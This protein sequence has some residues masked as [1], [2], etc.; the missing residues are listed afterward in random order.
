MIFLFVCGF[1][2]KVENRV[3]FLDPGHGGID[4]GCISNKGVYEKGIVL[5]IAYYVKDYLEINGYNVMMTRYGDYDLASDYS[6]NRKHEDILRRV[7]MIN[8]N[9]CYAVISLHA[10]AFSDRNITGAQCFYSK[11]N[12]GGEIL[13]GIIQDKLNKCINNNRVSMAIKDKYVLDNVIHPI[14]LI[15]VGFLSNSNDASNL[16]NYDY[17]KMIAYVVG[18][19]IIEFINR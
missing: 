4:G 11:G 1:N 3:I 8:N 16:I 7:E 10:N 14:A 15:E 9:E 5:D 6:K 2:N 18:D 13:S 12:K 17:Q 19:S